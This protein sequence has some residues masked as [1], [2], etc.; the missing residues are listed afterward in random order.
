MRQSSAIVIDD[1]IWVTMKVIMFKYLE[2][3]TSTFLIGK[4]Y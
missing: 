4:M 3:E 2:N 1:E